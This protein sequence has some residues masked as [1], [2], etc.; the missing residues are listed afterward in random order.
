MVS[1]FRRNF[2]E[3]ISLPEWLYYFRITTNVKTL[4]AVN[5]AG[6]LYDI[7]ET[8]EALYQHANRVP[9]IKGKLH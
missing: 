7:F 3:E 6:L 5:K 4:P 9:K 2:N 1:P 8:F